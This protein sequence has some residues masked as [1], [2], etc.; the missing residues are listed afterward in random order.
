MLD[1]RQN[2]DLSGKSLL[3]HIVADALASEAACTA[4]SKER[5]VTPLGI[6]TRAYKSKGSL[7]LLS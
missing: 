4:G 1:S 7:S 2:K 6:I 5:G 3:S